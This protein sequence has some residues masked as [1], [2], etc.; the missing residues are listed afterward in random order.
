[1]TAADRPVVVVTGASTGIGHATALAL[2][3]SG[4][5][6]AAGVR[7]DDD[8]ERLRCAADHVH[9][10][11][12]DVSD[13]P[14]VTR[15]MAR[16][17]ALAGDRGVAGLVNN[18]G[19]VRGGPVE[20][21]PDDHWREQFEVNVLGQVVVTRAALDLLRRGRGRIVFI[22][23]ISGKVSTPL[24]APYSASKF[25]IEAIAEALRHEL[26]P[27]GTR[28]VVV[29]PGAVRTPVW[30]KGRRLIDVLERRVPPEALTRYETAI[31]ELRAS[32]DSQERGA[33]APEKVAAVVLRALTVRRPRGR[34]PVGLDARLGGVLD[35]VAPIPVRDV[36]VR[37]VMGP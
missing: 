4:F 6:V 23:S 37:A 27:W 10:V 29:G 17:S 19:I 9:P 22:G 2:A 20:Y 8:A 35:R 33:I 31:A 26:R 25:A 30:E 18:A 5:D 36:L 12:L 13:E 28:V 1:V 24:L 11:L 32:L 7:T 21:V 16:V 34:Y 14:S 3:R 15:A